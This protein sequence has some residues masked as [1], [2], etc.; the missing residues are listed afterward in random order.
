MSSEY[1][2][3]YEEIKKEKTKVMKDYEEVY[4]VYIKI[5][6]EYDALNK[7]LEATLSEYQTKY[8][9]KLEPEVMLKHEMKARL[10]KS[11]IDS[12]TNKLAK[13]ADELQEA[14]KAIEVENE[15]I[16][17]FDQWW[18]Q[19]RENT[20]HNTLRSVVLIFE[21]SVVKIEE[22]F[23]VLFKIPIS[24]IFESEKVQ[25]NPEDMPQMLE[26]QMQEQHEKPS[27]LIQK[28]RKSIFS[29][30]L[31]M[32]QPKHRKRMSTVLTKP[33][34]GEEDLKLYGLLE[35]FKNIMEEYN[36]HY[37]E[38]QFQCG[39]ENKKSKEL[40]SVLKSLAEYEDEHIKERGKLVSLN[41]MNLKVGKLSTYWK[42]F[43]NN[44]YLINM[45]ST[46]LHNVR[47]YTTS[48]L[49][50]VENNIIGQIIWRIH[51]DSG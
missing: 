11:Q 10:V 17:T 44:V 26:G 51:Q 21:E 35:D 38:D 42:M 24:P 39:E 49:I 9:K 25:N 33:P 36:L 16:V 15:K 8:K 20:C 22:S 2:E 14:I 12:L 1:E 4:A 6:T 28:A 50:Y 23:E 5:K 46:H 34:V 19:K 3:K 18:D 27:R 7:T 32:A 47:L 31:E 41:F 37:T 40:I 13:S 30:P 48:L 29:I 45:F 43:Q